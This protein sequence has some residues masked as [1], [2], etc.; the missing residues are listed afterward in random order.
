MEDMLE[1]G[2]PEVAKFLYQSKDVNEDLASKLIEARH[3]DIKK[4]QR[5]RDDS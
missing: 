5:A 3:E 2:D 4:L 1:K